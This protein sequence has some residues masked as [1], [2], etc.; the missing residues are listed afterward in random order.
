MDQDGAIDRRRWFHW[1]VST[2]ACFGS[3][4]RPT[5]MAPHY[6]VGC[7]KCAR[8]FNNHTISSCQNKTGAQREKRYWELGVL[9]EIPDFLRQA[10]R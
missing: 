4:P 1:A 7:Y 8:T 6:T 2:A 9:T 5:E 10:V 3:L